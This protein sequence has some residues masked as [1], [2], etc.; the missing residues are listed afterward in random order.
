MEAIEHVLAKRRGEFAAIVGAARGVYARAKEVQARY[1]LVLSSHRAL[2]ARSIDRAMD[3]HAAVFGQ[4]RGEESVLSVA[5]IFN[6]PLA[7]QCRLKSRVTRRL[8]RGFAA[9]WI[10]FGR[11]HVRGKRASARER[12]SGALG[13][14]FLGHA[15]DAKLSRVGVRHSLQVRNV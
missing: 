1:E 2:G 13:V 10:R 6:R 11:Y 14:L 9:D 3:G 7:R 15:R 8:R 12:G 4:E 5:R